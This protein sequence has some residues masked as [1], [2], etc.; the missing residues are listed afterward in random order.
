M[1]TLLTGASGF[2]GRRV[3]KLLMQNNEFVYAFGRNYPKEIDHLSSVKWIHGDI[4]TG[5]GLEDIPW[6][7]ISQ[8]IHLAASGV[9]ASHRNWSEAISVNVVGTQRLLT[10]ISAQRVCPKL[11]LARTFYEK[12]IHQAPGLLNNPYIATKLASSELGFMFA[13]HYPEAV[14][15]GTFFQVYGPGDAP[16]NVLSYAAR[17]IKSG[18]KAVIGSGKGLRDWIY[19][20]D[21]AR[22]VVA[23]IKH[24][25]SGQQTTV[26]IGNGSL[27][28][29]RGVVER[30]AEICGRNPEDAVRFN[31]SLDRSD[32]D[33]QA[34]AEE[35]PTSWS[36]SVSLDDGLTALL[37]SL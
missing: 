32:V 12:L 20:D 28:S 3:L 34:Q 35:F 2:I 23:S 6:K 25:H 17:E 1:A 31:S 24:T 22:A 11:F 36:P 8:V 15:F 26:D 4:A 5:K 13:R 14:C 19:I 21:A 27:H 30:L 7:D 16:E 10:C 9:K 18:G 37:S 29:I 33:L